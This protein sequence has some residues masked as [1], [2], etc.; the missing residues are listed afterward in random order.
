MKGYYKMLSNMKQ[1]KALLAHIFYSVSFFVIFI[2]ALFYKEKLFLMSNGE[3]FL[4]AVIT[5]LST[6]ILYI[7]FVRYLFVPFHILSIKI[8]IFKEKYWQIIALI[9]LL[10]AFTA[11]ITAFIIEGQ[12]EYNQERVIVV[13]LFSL[14]VG[15]VFKMRTYANGRAVLLSSSTDKYIFHNLKT[16]GSLF[17]FHVLI[18]CS[19]SLT[20]SV[21]IISLG[22]F[23]L[24]AI[25]TEYIIARIYESYYITTIG[26]AD[27]NIKRTKVKTQI[28]IIYDYVHVFLG[29]I[30]TYIVSYLL[31]II[32]NCN[33]INNEEFEIFRLKATVSVGKYNWD[34]KKYTLKDMSLNLLYTYIH[35]RFQSGDN[36]KEILNEFEDISEKIRAHPKILLLESFILFQNN[37]PDEAGELLRGFIKKYLREN[38][39][40]QLFDD[41]PIIYS[42]MSNNISYSMYLTWQGFRD[43][44]IDLDDYTKSIIPEAQYW[45]NE[46]FTFSEPG[47]TPN[48]ISLWHT[49]GCIQ[50]L[51]NNNVEAIEDFAK[52]VLISDHPSSRY[53]LALFRM[54]GAGLFIRAESE[55]KVLLHSPHVSA[56]SL[57]A[58]DIKTALN[59]IEIAR[60]KGIRFNFNYIH[61]AHIPA[62][63]IDY[64]ASFVAQKDE[65]FEIEQRR[66]KVFKAIFTLKSAFPLINIFSYKYR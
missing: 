11:I 16:Y 40:R 8:G 48:K 17:I 35:S 32:N 46:A 60:K 26:I 51:T 9:M 4:G 44:H 59:H 19:P 31:K 63:N 10:L 42:I 1:P 34:R 65:I 41:F 6:F 56:N 28:E 33:L 30:G 25:S 47:I 64:N 61:Y 7:L 18:V 23:W 24:S 66:D 58:T 12:I 43:E 52:N 57:L 62:L 38:N 21:R 20:F 54:I 2:A 14:F 3:I 49:R 37:K 50:L 55:L 27:K 53:H 29:N 39:G 13:S 22:F 5:V 36:P 15:F 45:I